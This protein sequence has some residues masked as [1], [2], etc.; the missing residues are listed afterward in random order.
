[1]TPTANTRLLSLGLAGLA[2][3]RRSSNFPCQDGLRIEGSSMKIRFLIGCFLTLTAC[4]EVN[5][6]GDCIKNQDGNVV[7]GK[8]QCATD[9][10]GKVFCAKEGGGAMRDQYGNVKCGVGYC[11]T[12]EH[13]Q[14]KCST[15]QGGGA[16]TASN[17]KVKCLGGCQSAK[18]QLCE[19][20][21]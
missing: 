18:T 6:A 15:K 17:G 21:R 13:G 16:T 9:Q 4:T 19:V 2:L 5:A 7:C 11:A 10:Y 14:L 20:A 8:G 1:M 12:D 3:E